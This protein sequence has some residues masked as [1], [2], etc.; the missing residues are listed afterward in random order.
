M[1]RAVSEYRL[2]GIRTT[3]PFFERVLLHP[4]FVKGE[5]DTAFVPRLLE[6]AVSRAAPRRRDRGA[7]IARLRRAA[8]RAQ[9]ACGARRL[10]FGWSATGRR[11]AHSARI[12]TGG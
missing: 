4:A 7:A 11:D 2:L 1:R 3:L 6:E 5:L 8:P 10:G 12:G 9:S